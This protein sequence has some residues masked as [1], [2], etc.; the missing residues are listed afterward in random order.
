MNYAAVAIGRLGF[1]RPSESH[2]SPMGG[3]IERAAALKL[4]LIWAPS[5][6]EGVGDGVVV[7]DGAERSEPPPSTCFRTDPR[8][9]AF[10]DVDKFKIYLATWFREWLE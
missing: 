8:T 5:E 2:M 1:A 7:A 6:H 9:H 4:L 10:D 3:E